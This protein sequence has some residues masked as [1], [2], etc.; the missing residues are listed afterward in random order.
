MNRPVKRSSE[1]RKRQR[2]SSGRVRTGE[3]AVS[4]YNSIDRRD[5]RLSR[6]GRMENAVQ[7]RRAQR[8][9]AKRHQRINRRK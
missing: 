4:H 1:V 6:V 8:K 3:G 9:A 5:R 2:R 7:R